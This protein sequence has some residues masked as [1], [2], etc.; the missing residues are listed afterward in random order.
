MKLLFLL[1]LFNVPH[2]ETVYLVYIYIEWI[3]LRRDTDVQ[4]LSFFIRR[5]RADLIWKKK[6]ATKKSVKL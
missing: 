2:H 1:F 6:M 5:N 4:Y 3:R